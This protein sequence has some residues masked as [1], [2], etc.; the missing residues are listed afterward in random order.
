MG[1]DPSLPVAASV[2]SFPCSSLSL[3]IQ[4]GGVNIVVFAQF[5]LY[6]IKGHFRY[7]VFFIDDV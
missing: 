1:S 5:D 7:F 3:A 4:T 6:P 2:A